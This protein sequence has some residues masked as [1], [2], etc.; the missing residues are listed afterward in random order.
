ML[1]FKRPNVLCRVLHPVRAVVGTELGKCRVITAAQMEPRFLRCH[2][3]CNDKFF[4]GRSA[5]Q[6]CLAKPPVE[7]ASV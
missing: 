4:W 7:T 1:P 2:P 3:T 6:S 5:V